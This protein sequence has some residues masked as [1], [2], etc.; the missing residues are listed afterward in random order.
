MIAA[1]EP[2][3]APTDR[4]ALLRQAIDLRAARRAPEA[5]AV[6]DRLQGLHPRFSRA[7][8]ERGHCHVLL[9]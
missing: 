8:Q 9:G 4:D 6:L 3:G 5:L 2:V 1:A 7:L